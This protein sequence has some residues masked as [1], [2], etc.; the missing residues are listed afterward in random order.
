MKRINIFKEKADYPMSGMQIDL[1][2]KSKV[3]FLFW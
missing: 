1:F 2:Q 3:N